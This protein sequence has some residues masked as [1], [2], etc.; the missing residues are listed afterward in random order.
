VKGLA[1]RLLRVHALRAADALQLGAALVWA[2]GRPQG[3]V[4]LTL[5]E[6]LA[7]IAKREGFEVP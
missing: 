7:L 2:G 1:R 6:R 3:K 5:D 4:L